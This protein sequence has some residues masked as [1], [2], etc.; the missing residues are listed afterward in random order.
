MLMKTRPEFASIKSVL[1]LEEEAV[2][3]LAT[4]D[5]SGVERNLQIVSATSLLW[6]SIMTPVK[7]QRSCG[8]CW[9]FGTVAAVESMYKKTK[10]LTL[11]LADQ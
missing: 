1:T 7:N 6:T 5:N 10:G 2:S 11:N 8:S 9:A 3:A 4:Q